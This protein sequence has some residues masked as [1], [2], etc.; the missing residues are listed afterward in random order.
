MRLAGLLSHR[1]DRARNC[2]HG[3]VPPAARQAAL[4]LGARCRRLMKP[5]FPWE[6]WR[7]FRRRARNDELF[8]IFLAVVSGCVASAGVI[9]RARARSAGCGA[10]RIGIGS[11]SDGRRL[12]ADMHII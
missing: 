3:P 11:A 10:I 8:L 7:S 12:V 2:L 5:K 4:P 9:A 1:Y 6:A